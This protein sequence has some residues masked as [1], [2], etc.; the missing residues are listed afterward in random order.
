MPGASSLTQTR[1]GGAAAT[2]ASLAGATGRRDGAAGAG[3]ARAFIAPRRPRADRRRRLAHRRPAAGRARIVDRRRH[4]LRVLRRRRQW[5]RRYR[6]RWAGIVVGHGRQRLA[7][8]DEA[9]ASLM[10]RR[11]DEAIAGARLADTARRK[12]LLPVLPIPMPSPASR[13]AAPSSDRLAPAPRAPAAQDLRAEAL[14][15]RP[16][17]GDRARHGGRADARGD[18]DRR[19]QVALLSA[20]R[21]AAAGDDAGRLAA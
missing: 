15:R 16:G 20:A 19:R 6:R 13:R 4:A 9:G 14:A 7:R 5:R 18:A 10:P 3:R 1:P 11:I 21:A 17:G 2:S 12:R 8:T